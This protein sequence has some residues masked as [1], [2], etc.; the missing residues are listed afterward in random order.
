MKQLLII[1]CG[2]T[3]LQS[4]VNCLHAND[5]FRYDYPEALIMQNG[6]SEKQ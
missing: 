4:A 3:V 1:L 5:D 2:L 6:N